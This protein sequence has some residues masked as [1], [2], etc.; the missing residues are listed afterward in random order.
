MHT[1]SLTKWYE[2]FQQTQSMLSDFMEDHQQQKQ[3][4]ECQPFFNFVAAEADKF[5]D[6]QYDNILADVLHLLQKY[7]RVQSQSQET[8]QT[9]PQT[10]TVGNSPLTKGRCY[11]SGMLYLPC[12]EHSREMVRQRHHQ[13]LAAVAPGFFFIDLYGIYVHKEKA[14]RQKKNNNKN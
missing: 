1:V 10:C 12:P 2:L 11:T 6:A 4:N 14:Q 9:Q 13:H 5:S 8:P 7:K 3:S